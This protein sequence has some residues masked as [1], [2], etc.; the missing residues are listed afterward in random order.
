MKAEKPTQKMLKMTTLIEFILVQLTAYYEE[1][2]L[3]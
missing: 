2:I 1:K 3:V